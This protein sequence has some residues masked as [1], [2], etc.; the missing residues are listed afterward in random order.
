MVKTFL[1]KLQKQVV[2][3]NST[4]RMA[5]SDSKN[6]KILVKA[7][8][9]F[10]SLG[11]SQLFPSKVVWNSWILI[12][13]VFF[14]MRSNMG[15]NIDFGPIEQGE[16]CLQGTSVM[17]NR[18]EESIDNI[19]LHCLLVGILQRLFFSLF[20]IDWV[21]HS[22]LRPMLLSWNRLFVR[23]RRKKVQFVAHLC[24]VFYWAIWWHKVRG[25]LEVWEFQNKCSNP[26]LCTIFFF[27]N[28][29]LCQALYRRD[30]YVYVGFC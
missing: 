28:F 22:S 9:S 7:F 23:K 6:R 21:T 16:E 20:R 26:I 4:D 19:F 14:S 3:R 13:V 29:I 1:Q 8:Y 27:F 18:E 10:L 30:I 11:G 24:R 5:W 2:I 17:C 15:K 12:R 25:L